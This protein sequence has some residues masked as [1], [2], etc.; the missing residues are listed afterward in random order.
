MPPDQPL[1]DAERVAYV[2]QVKRGAAAALLAIP[3]VLLVALGGKETGGRNTGELVIRVHVANKRPAGEVPPEELIPAE[4]GGV[5]TDV[6]SSGGKRLI[7]APPGGLVRSDDTDKQTKRPVQGGV[8]LTTA[9]SSADGSVFR[10]TL[11]CL[12]WSPTNHEVGFALTNQHVIDGDRALTVT[13][14]VTEVGQPS[15]NTSSCCCN[16]IIGVY[17]AGERTDDSDQA[18]VRLAPGTKWAAEIIEIGLVAGSRPLTPID[19]VVNTPVRKRGVRTGL[20]GGV[21]TDVGGLDPTGDLSVLV[22]ANDNPARQPGELLFFAE[23]GDSG[24]VLVDDGNKVVALLYAGELTRAEI[25]ATGGTPDPLPPDGIERPKTY[26]WPIADVLTRF[27]AGTP[28]LT[29][30]VATATVANQVHTVPGAATVA[31]PAELSAAVAA[32]P[33]AFLGSAAAGEL[34]APVGRAWF[35]ADLPPDETIAAVRAEL[36]R[37]A[38]GQLLFELVSRHRAEVTRLLRDDRRVG[39]AWHRGG[40]AAVFQLL[41]RMLGRPELELPE[42]VSGTP[43]GDLLD[44]LVAVL[45]ERGSPELGA[46]LRRARAVLPDVAGRTLPEILAALD[47]VPAGVGSDA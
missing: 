8:R 7:A 16:D 22:S 39:V 4:I 46:D 27:G 13:K 45:A 34:R 20:T 40:G 26:C 29:L 38:A 42:T 41:L 32:E 3:G 18:V 43:V 9:A 17:A 33:A 25:A 12:L 36:A 6:I 31:V 47:A 30:E 28:P 21:V 44:R 1:P 24:S 23:E 37:S 5:R 35:V 19:A 11:G 10:G 15:G 2:E 14:G